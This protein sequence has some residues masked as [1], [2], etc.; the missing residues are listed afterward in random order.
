MKIELQPDTYEYL[1]SLAEPFVD[2]PETVLNRLIRQHQK[3]TN[4]GKKNTTADLDE[5][6]EIGFDTPVYRSNNLPPMKHTRVL[7]GS[8]EGDSVDRA[9]WK[10]LLDAAILASC[11]KGNSAA[12]IVKALPANAQVGQKHGPGFGYIEEADVSYQGLE[13]SRCVEAILALARAFQLAVNIEFVW[14][15]KP[16]AHAPGKAGLIVWP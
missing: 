4:S 14:R 8:I 9:K 5:R 12:E 13:A 15:D 16:G 1:K 7:S 3:M 11:R 6:S 10:S 2:T